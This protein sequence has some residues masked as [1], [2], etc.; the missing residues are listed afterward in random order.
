[1]DSYTTN[2]EILMNA[3]LQQKTE[4]RKYFIEYHNI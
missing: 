1:M 2:E 4:W 3:T